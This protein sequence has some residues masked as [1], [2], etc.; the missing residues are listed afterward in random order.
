MHLNLKMICAVLLVVSAAGVV[1][2]DMHFFASQ[3]DT[4]SDQG[5][6]EEVMPPSEPEPTSNPKGDE[7]STGIR[8]DALRRIVP[9]FNMDL[10]VA[11]TEAPGVTADAQNRGDTTVVIAVPPEQNLLGK[12]W[13]DT[14]WDRLITSFV[15][16]EQIRT[17]PS[18]NQHGV[19]REEMIHSSA[20]VLIPIRAGNEEIRLNGIILGEGCASALINGHILHTGDR[21][22][23]REMIV[24]E[25]SK[26]H[27]LLQWERTRETMI[28]FLEPMKTQAPVRLKERDSP[29]DAAQ[30]KEVPIPDPEPEKHGDGKEAPSKAL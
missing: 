6:T 17:D 4:S 10:A 14:P 8:G 16:K 28:K 23:D 30:P 26:N 22:P 20:D 12:E 2:Y 13:K 1:G 21:L 29:A 5:I 3:P 24:S 25:I 7:K 9:R 27:V 18:S 15:E 19:L 11:G